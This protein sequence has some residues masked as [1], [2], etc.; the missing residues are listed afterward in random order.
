VN[1]G[2]PT[3][4]QSIKG[5][6]SH[7]SIQTS[8]LIKN[9]NVEM[10]IIDDIHHIL[11]GHRTKPEIFINEIAKI[12]TDNNICIVCTGIPIIKEVVISC[13]FFIE[14]ITE[15]TPNNCEKE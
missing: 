9:R 2:A 7:M 4:P 6:I 15:N 5:S 11:H 10:I 8:V 13:N 12:S 14:E 1:I 3:N